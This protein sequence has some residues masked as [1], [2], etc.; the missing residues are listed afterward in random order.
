MSTLW[1]E[2]LPALEW[3]GEPEEESW[4][5]PFATEM[6]PWVQHEVIGEDER[7]LVSNTLPVPYRWICGLDVTFNKPYPRNWPGGFGRGTG[8]LVGPREVLTA[9]HNI[10]PDGKSGPASVYVT[11]GRNGDLEPFGRVKAVAYSVPANAFGK[12]GILQW[13]D[14]AVV[15]LENAVGRQSFKALGNEPLGY[16]GSAKLGQATMLTA[17]NLSFMIGKRVTVC[18]YPGDRCGT[19]PYVPKTR[20]CSKQDQ[21]STQW[22]HNGVVS[23]MPKSSR[24]FFHTADTYAG[25]SGSPVWIKFTNGRRYLVGVHVDAHRVI[26]DDKFSHNIAVHLSNHVLAIVRSWIKGPL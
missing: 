17:L 21:A 18:G 15:T 24:R 23:A 11:P 26:V 4:S 3:P 13:Y 5:T 2:D 14:Y 1:S 22:V 20:T 6:A 9:A 7:Q 10:Y 16:W 25:Q 19:K 8:L 12:R